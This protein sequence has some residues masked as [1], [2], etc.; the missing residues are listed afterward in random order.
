VGS[1]GREGGRAHYVLGPFSHGDLLFPGSREG[2][3]VGLG[4]ESG[5]TEGREGGREGGRDGG[6]SG[7]ELFERRINGWREGGREGGS[8]EAKRLSVR[9]M[10]R[11]LRLVLVTRVEALREGREGGREELEE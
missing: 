10:G 9:H 8:E 5:G 4:D 1:E 2:L 3:G 7:Q 11:G 6:W